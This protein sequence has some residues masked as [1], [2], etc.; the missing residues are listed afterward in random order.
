M[1]AISSTAG[2]QKCRVRSVLAGR[3]NSYIL[4]R[5]LSLRDNAAEASGIAV[6]T[7]KAKKPLTGSE[8]EVSLQQLGGIKRRQ[9]S[10]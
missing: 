6:G 7:T 1:A 5:P 3:N 9:A 10:W 4:G 2:S 8:E